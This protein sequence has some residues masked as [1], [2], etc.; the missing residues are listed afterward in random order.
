MKSIRSKDLDLNNKK[1]LIRLDLNVPLNGTNIIDTNRIDKIIPT[2]EY[3]LKNKAKIIIL[4]HIGRPKGKV[5]N[6]LSLKPVCNELEKKLN[7]KISFINNN[8][9]KIKFVEGQPIEA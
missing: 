5:V 9:N 4:S 1:I 2:L 8:I 3:L 7:R 6:E